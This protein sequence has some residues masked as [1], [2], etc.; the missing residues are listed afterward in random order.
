MSENPV[1][2]AIRF[3]LE[4]G[5]LG[6]L[7]YWGWTQHASVA[8]FAWTFGLVILA[9]TVWAVFRVP[10][11]GGTPVVAVAGWIRLLIETAYFSGATWALLASGQRTWGFVFGGIVV[12]HYLA[13]YDRIMRFLGF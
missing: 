3:L 11:D 13:S 1:N 2:L 12:L 6:A 10:G 9:A 7:G 8:R 4:L 5:G